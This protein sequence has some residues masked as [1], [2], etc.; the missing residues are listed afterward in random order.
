MQFA[1]AAAE[2]TISNPHHSKSWQHQAEHCISWLSQHIG[3]KSVEKITVGDLHALQRAMLQ[4]GN[5]KPSSINRRLA[6]ARAI[7][8][9]SWREEHRSRPATFKALKEERRCKHL[10]QAQ[11]KNLINQLPQ[12]YKD[13]ADLSL[14]TGLR[15]ANILKLEW[16][17]VDEARSCIVIPSGHHKNRQ[18]HVAPITARAMHLIQQWRGKHAQFVFI[19]KDGKPLNGIASKVWQTACKSAGLSDFRWHDLRHTWASWLDR[20]SK[21]LS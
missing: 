16:K 4:A 18:P 5:L 8:N 14:C 13:M 19:R 6:V 7:L 21:V 17:W 12:P 9:H 11:A 20:F 10:N 3:D 15:Q 2:W 1:Q